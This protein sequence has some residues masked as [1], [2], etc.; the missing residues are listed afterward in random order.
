MSQRPAV[1]L[2]PWELI[3]AAH[4]GIRRHC[5]N[6]MTPN[7]H[8]LQPT[9]AEWHY[10]ILGAIGECVLAK[11]LGVYWTGAGIAGP[12]KGDVGKNLR[13]RTTREPAFFV[14]REALHSIE[15]LAL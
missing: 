8:N 14:E 13:V 12:D 15:K 2:T 5:R 11:H 9:E 3:D 6:V 1:V 10:D 7:R 4:V